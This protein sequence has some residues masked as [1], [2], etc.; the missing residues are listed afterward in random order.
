MKSYLEA[1]MLAEM[2]SNAH[3]N[4][5]K[6]FQELIRTQQELLKIQQEKQQQSFQLVINKE[7]S[8][9]RDH[10]SQ[11]MTTLTDHLF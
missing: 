8:I 10:A 4:I 2:H 6:S 11:F 5:Q 3:N 9:D 7:K 1:L